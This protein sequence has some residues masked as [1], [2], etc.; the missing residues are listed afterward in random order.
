MK[1]DSSYIV[2]R[3]I[4]NYLVSVTHKAS[5]LKDARYLLK[6]IAKPN[7]AIFITALH[8]QYKGSGEPTYMCHV[9][10]NSQAEFNETQWLNSVFANS[11]S[12]ELTFISNLS[13]NNKNSLK[14]DETSII[15]INE[16]ST[17]ALSLTIDK[18][19]SILKMNS[20]QIDVILS[21]PSKWINWES[22]MMLMT[23]DVYVISVNPESK[24]PLT[25]TMNSGMNKEKN[26]NSDIDYNSEMK[27]IIRSR[28]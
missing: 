6:H 13:E 20:K 11:R 4:E 2:V 18:I 3:P 12:S 25:L 14:L 8:A 5:S 22:V 23:N 10:E 9:K 19:E 15:E 28:V 7:D 16:K 26:E 24:W 21:E 1:W 17:E 27:F